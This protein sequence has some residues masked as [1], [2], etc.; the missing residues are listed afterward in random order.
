GLRNRRFLAQNIEREIALARRQPHDLV[1]FLIDVDHFKQVN[2][3]YGH[4]AGDDVLVQV[5]ERLE[6]VF[7]GSDFLIR[8]GGEEFLAVTRGMRREDAG[9]MAQR[10]LRAVEDRP[11]TLSDGVAL[12]KTVSIGFAGYPFD[13]ERPEAHTWWQVIECADAALYEA[14]ESGRNAWRAAHATSGKTLRS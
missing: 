8:W 14:K 5:R 2:D 1:F 3:V 13:P 10:V 9:E 12:H 4:R 6:E 7:R 11:F